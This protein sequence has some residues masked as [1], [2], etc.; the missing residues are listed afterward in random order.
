M[1]RGDLGDGSLGSL[2][3]CQMGVSTLGDFSP[4]ISTSDPLVVCSCTR[5]LLLAEGAG[6]GT[7]VG[8]GGVT[9][10]GAGGVTMDGALRA[11][12][13]LISWVGVGGSG[14]G[15]GGGV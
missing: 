2:N 9:D 10:V 13:V 3:L 7:I 1:G 14:E 11:E 15:A 4:F 5:P 8:A 6:D 12:L